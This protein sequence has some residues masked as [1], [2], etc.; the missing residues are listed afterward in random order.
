MKF[1]V[2][3]VFLLI[4]MHIYSQDSSSDNSK[5]ENEKISLEINKYFDVLYPGDSKNFIIYKGNKQITK[6]YFVALSNDEVLIKNQKY[7]K[8][9]KL[10]GFISSS[11]FGAASLTFFIPSVVF[12]GVETYFYRTQTNY[13]N[14]GYQSWIDFFSAK[15]SPYIL[16]GLSC[17]VSSA[18]CFLF[19]IIDLAITFGII[20]NYQSN[21]KIYKDAIE[22]YNEKLRKKFNIKPDL[23]IDYKQTVNLGLTIRF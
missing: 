12:F 11:I 16:S 7:V 10:A 9:T 4:S 3:L 23:D 5:Y 19:M 13:Q 14:L 18:A 1:R 21:E 6:E 22:K 8:K 15:Y 2:I 20:H 17:M